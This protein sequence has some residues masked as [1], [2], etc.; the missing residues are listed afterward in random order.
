MP[1]SASETRDRGF[2]AAA[3]MLPSWNDGPARQ[4]I[5]GFVAQ[6][7]DDTG[8]GFVPPANRIATFDQ[9]GTLWVEQPIY[10]QVAFAFERLA[11]LAKYRPELAT[12]EPFKSVLSRDMAAI[13]QFTMK[14][15]EPIAAITHSGM[16]VDA[17]QADVAEWIGQARHPRFG[18][19]YTELT[20][21]PMHEVMAYLNAAGFAVYIVTGGGQDFVRVFAE[22]TYGVPRDRV[23]GSV[24]ATR[25]GHDAAG[26]PVLT[27]IPA[28]TLNND[29]ATK[30]E[31]IHMMIGRRPVIAFGNSAGDEP[32]LDYA[33]GGGTGLGLLL[34]HDDEI[35]EYAYGPANGL[36]PSGIGSFPQA[37]YDRAEAQG[38]TVISM[39]HD[40]NRVFAFE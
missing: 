31:G 21:Q 38:W 18:R 12:S 2:I 28:L 4:A 5:I 1:H 35:R 33:T 10:T 17:F 36:P 40:W 16:T 22:E 8:P 30:P 25:F 39:K 6:C 32:M 27:K 29:L 24:M 7:T 15:L 19:P 26:L 11:I 13:K 34:L 9:D 20:Y 3:E 23:V 14:D 37:L